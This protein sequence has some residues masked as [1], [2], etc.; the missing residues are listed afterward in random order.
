MQQIVVVIYVH[1]LLKQ[2]F[3]IMLTYTYRYLKGY[4]L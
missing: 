4:N 1:V 3:I 2:L